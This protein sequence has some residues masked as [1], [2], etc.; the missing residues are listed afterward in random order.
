MLI[1]FKWLSR[2]IDLSGLAA[3]RIASD[4]TLAT[5]EVE[6]VEEFLPHARSIVVGKVL[7]RDPHPKADR[8]SLCRV[9]LGGPEPVP[10]VCGAANVAA[11]QTVPVAVPGTVLPGIGKLEKAKIRGEVSLGM[12]CSE[13][14]VGLADESA[15]IWVLP[16]DLA[17]G[18]SLADALDLGDHVIEVDNK[19]ITHR[20]DLWGHR[21]IARELSA[22]YRRPLLPLD[23]S[24]PAL[25]SGA[26]FPVK[27][28]SPA[29]AR[30]LALPIEGVEALPSP[31]W[32]RVLLRAV[33][34]RSLGQLVDLSNFVM[35][36]LG[37]P[38]HTFDRNQL[39]ADGI[40]VRKARAGERFTTLAG[41]A[42]TLVDDD[43]LIASRGE[44]VALAGVIGGQ[45]SEVRDGTRSLLLEVATFDAPT[46]R[47]TSQ[48]HGLRTDSSARFE[49]SLDPE[50]P[51]QAAAHFA[52][53]LSQL[54]PK[55][56]FPAPVT[57][58]RTSEPK[59]VEI[60]LRPSR[61]RDALGADLSDEQI[62][63]I[64]LRL[65][66]G[67]SEQPGAGE[68]A[69]WVRVPS[70]RATK[71]IG[72]ERDLVEEVGRMHGYGNITERPLVC[73]IV[74]PPHD[75]R[76]WLVRKVADRLAGAAHFTETLSYSFQPDDLLASFGLS[77]LPHATLQ[78]PVV[79]QQSRIR[80][81]LVPSLLANIEAN[82][83]YRD[84]VRLFEIGKG[85]FPENAN[86]KHEPEERHIAGLVLAA[87]LKRDAGYRDNSLARLQ[88]VVA[89]V[90]SV[91]ERPSVEWGPADSAP[92]YAQSGRAL[93]A[94][95]PSGGVAA[96]LVAVRQDVL[97]GLGLKA[98]LASDVAACEISLDAVL[99]A[100]RETRRYAPMPR[101][102]G[103]KVDV[104]IAVPTA[105]RSAQVVDVIKSAAG[106]VCRAVELF[107]L[108]TGDVLGAG[109]KS[110]AYHVLLQ[111]D[112][113]TLGE[114]EER[115]FL[116]RL[117][118]KLGSIDG[119]LRD[120]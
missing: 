119:A 30:Y 71:D 101:F 73:P 58:V 87:P 98:G 64:L 74:P 67:V 96:T 7:S 104:A 84:E 107:D 55:V 86:D 88:A 9:D 11:G 66:F 60:A 81:T 112:D 39:G 99:A 10:I 29:C 85:Y 48:R 13:Q 77:E 103:I 26:A 61:V 15:G 23:T 19:S 49:K 36:D 69:L 90:L 59:S 45:N 17:P 21:G 32:L 3:S 33:G 110:L 117:G 72:I 111:A 22:I 94:R 91:L 2:H 114:S 16:D 42:L 54:Q 47:R 43:L 8:L 28:E 82:R 93:V 83:R 12:I 37:Q 102:P 80:R 14:E 79:S 18:R 78:N 53:L 100:Q 20:P 116:D 6:G 62:K 38:N 63:D 70:D 95:Y 108:Y 46:V 118:S 115:K 105:V 57:D 52:R 113:K 41:Q 31:L 120:G 106:S 50:L 109:K 25:G 24:W 5:A 92:P 89:D 65:N 35:L 97:S 68:T 34:Q 51:P 76:R 27:I 56:S 1:S 44:G 40:A 4:L 75:E